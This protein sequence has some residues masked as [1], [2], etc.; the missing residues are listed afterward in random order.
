MGDARNGRVPIA[1]PTL[2]YLYGPPAAG[3]LTIA[4]ALAEQSG[5]RLFHNHLTVNAVRAVF[6]F[7]SPPFIE[8]VQRMRLDVF[9]TAMRS[10][11]DVIFTNTSAWGG[12]DARARF[13][14]FASEVDDVVRGAGGTTCFVQVTAPEDVLVSRVALEW[15]H[16]HGKLTDATR[17]RSLLADLDSSPLHLDDLSVDTSVTDAQDAASRILGFV[18]KATK[19]SLKSD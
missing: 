19:A 15:R 16:A 1:V 10:D 2:V 12:D 5:F 4:E 9:A 3:K 7:G 8:L 13:A 6:D 17:L 18:Q 11:V 14:A